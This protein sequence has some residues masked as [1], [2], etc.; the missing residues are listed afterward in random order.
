MMVKNQF[1]MAVKMIRCDNGK[2]FVSDPILKFYEELSIIQHS[3]CLDT[4]QRNGRMERKH[5]QSL[6]LLGHS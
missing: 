5:H 4:P 1:S 6:M 2:E 3:S